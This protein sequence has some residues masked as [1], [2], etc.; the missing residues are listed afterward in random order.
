MNLPFAPE[1]V[2]RAHGP[3]IQIHLGADGG[4]VGA[5]AARRIRAPKERVWRIM[6]DLDGMAGRVPMMQ[7]IQRDGRFVTVHLRFGLSLFSAHFAFK[8]EHVIDEGR[9]IELRYVEGEPRD[10]TI[11]QELV[12]ASTPDATLLYT[13]I[14]YDVF[15]LGFL[16]KFFLK[17]HPEIRYGVIPGSALTLL[18][19]VRKAAEA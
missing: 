9:A 13:S 16:T 10:I 14:D 11:R 18:D 19:S 4:P 12:A 2:E 8:V 5:T 17:H 15:S 1:L 6:T 3:L 7:K